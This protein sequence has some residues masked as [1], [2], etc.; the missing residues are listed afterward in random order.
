MEIE[1]KYPGGAL[2][3][4]KVSA[5]NVNELCRVLNDSKEPFLVFQNTRG[6]FVVNTRNILS[7]R[8]K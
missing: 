4:A 5:E 6:S 3:T 7:V 1:I 2:E 8:R